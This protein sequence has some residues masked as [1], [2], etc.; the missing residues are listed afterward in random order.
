MFCL[1]FDYVNLYLLFKCLGWCRA[2][3]M[4]MNVAELPFHTCFIIK[5][6]IAR[7]MMGGNGLC[8][9]MSPPFWT[10]NHFVIDKYTGIYCWNIDVT[11]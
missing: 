7:Q 1:D 10:L 6:N 8:D 5:P 2:T 3:G 9:N 4:G 11:V